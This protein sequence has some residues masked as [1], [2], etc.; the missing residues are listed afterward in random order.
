MAFH[1]QRLH[2][3]P[4]GARLNLYVQPAATA[5]VGV[6]QINHGLAEHAARYARFAEFMA[7]HGFHTYAHDHRGH[8][9]TTATDAPLGRFAA[10]DGSAKVIADV[11][12]IHQLIAS[13]HPGL[14]VVLYGHSMGGIIALN[15]LLCHSDTVQ[16]AT[17][18]NANFSA[19]L[20]GRLAQALLAYERF[21]LGSDM[22]SRLLPK[23]TFQAWGKAVPGH[24]TDFDWLSRDAAEVGK[25]IADP[26]CGWD[27]S[28]SLWQDLFGMIFLGA[29]DS[30][31]A[32]VRKDLPIN[33]VGGEQDPATAGG[34]AVT[35]LASRMRAMGFSNLVSKVYAQTR[36]ESLNELNRD[37]IMEDFAAWARQAVAR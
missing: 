34:K 17:I 30:N 6:L 36:H 25:Y 10:R 16:A 11:A 8:G 14:P 21:R 19:G 3:S 35:T 22:P 7:A 29:D 12:A 9:H 27:A 33:L 1:N 28:V 26:L 13:E 15:Y 37:L 23:L 2:T 4:S 31:F 18:W 24:R 20:P 5:P 32:A